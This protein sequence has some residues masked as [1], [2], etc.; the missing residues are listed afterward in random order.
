MNSLLGPSSCIKRTSSARYRKG[1]AARGSSS[2]ITTKVPPRRPFIFPNETKS[3]FRKWPSWARRMWIYGNFRMSGRRMRT[4]LSTSCRNCWP[5]MTWTAAPATFLRMRVIPPNFPKAT[6]QKKVSR[7]TADAKK[8]RIKW[9][10]TNQ[11]GATP[12]QGEAEG[13][14]T[15]KKAKCCEW[16]RQFTIAR[17][18]EAAKAAKASLFDD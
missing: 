1:G 4:L 2:P 6:G 7:W 3:I 5:S 15:E 10:S 13:H 14:P 17:G 18:I 16:G 8:W 11:K 12:P 9:G